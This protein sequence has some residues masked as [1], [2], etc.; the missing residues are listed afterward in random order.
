MHSKPINEPAFQQV[1]DDLNRL[2]GY[3]ASD[4]AWRLRRFEIEH[5]ADKLPAGGSLLDVG[6]GPGFV[7]RYFH[8]L[9]FKVI[10]VDFPGT[11]GL[12]ALKALMDVGIEGHYL[13][14]GAKPLPLP[15][16]SLD[17]V[18]VGNVIE[19]L[20]DSPRPF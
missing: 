19:H 20:P 2:P 16:N 8:N 17:V 13:Q 7:P 11:G 10:S 9:G 12:D 6:S 18:F 14:V 4:P 1:G 3:G 5:I 15:D